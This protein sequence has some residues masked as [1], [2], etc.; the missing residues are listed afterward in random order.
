M[1]AVEV[2]ATS[3]PV[4]GTGHS[5][6]SVYRNKNKNEWQGMDLHHRSPKAS[7]LQRDAFDYSATLPY[8]GGCRLRSGVR[9]LQVS[10]SSY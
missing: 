2:A 6:A 7:R 1:V 5:T 8:G 4:Y 9:T 10:H 3:H